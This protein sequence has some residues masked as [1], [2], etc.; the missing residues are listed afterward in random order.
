MLNFD[1]S[2]RA[3]SNLLGI[4]AY[5]AENFGKLVAENVR[6][7]YEATFLL[8]RKFPDI[9]KKENSKYRSFPVN[10]RGRILYYIEKNTLFIVTI[11]DMRINP[12]SIDELIGK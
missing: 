7:K 12:Q 5:C 9:G 4:Y 1:I 3:I 11:W 8:L 2:Q 10:N 6:Q